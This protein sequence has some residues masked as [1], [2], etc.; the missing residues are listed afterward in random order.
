MPIKIHMPNISQQQKAKTTINLEIQII[1]HQTKK[2]VL[3]KLANVILSPYIYFIFKIGRSF[4]VHWSQIW[5]HMH[6]QEIWGFGSHLT[7]K[8]F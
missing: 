8:T 6:I 4:P 5:M 7:I 1:F 2:K 3:V